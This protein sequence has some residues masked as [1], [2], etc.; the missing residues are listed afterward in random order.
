MNLETTHRSRVAVPQ[1]IRRERGDNSL[2]I[3]SDQVRKCTGFEMNHDNLLGLVDEVRAVVRIDSGIRPPPSSEF[4]LFGFG[5]F[6]AI[7]ESSALAIKTKKR[8]FA[9][10]TLIPFGLAPNCFNLLPS[11]R[12]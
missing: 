11:G 8:P 5:L 1:L 9:S 10:K 12:T 7:F 2:L 4:V 6:D 3:G